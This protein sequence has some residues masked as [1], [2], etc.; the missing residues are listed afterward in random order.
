MR[1]PLSVNYVH[2][3]PAPPKYSNI[4][5]VL[6]VFKARPYTVLHMGREEEIAE[7]VQDV[8][9]SSGLI[10]SLATSMERTEHGLVLTIGSGERYEVLV[11]AASA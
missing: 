7:V 3:N 9:A 6:T 4:V 8:L 1:A 11:R 2:D 10:E 5:I